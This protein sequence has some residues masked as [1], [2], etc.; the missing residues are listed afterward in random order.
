MAFLEEFL[1]QLGHDSAVS[2]M[3]GGTLRNPLELLL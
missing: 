1:E 3:T 2:G